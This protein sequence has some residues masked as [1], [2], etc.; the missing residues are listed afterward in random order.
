MIQI[1]DEERSTLD[2]L[3]TLLKDT[4][5]E[6][7]DAKNPTEEQNLGFALLAVL[8][9]GCDALATDDETKIKA[10][11]ATLPAG[12][13]ALSTLSAEGAMQISSATTKL[14]VYLAAFK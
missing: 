8:Y 9:L 5:K 7:K 10:F 14:A 11:F 12:C 3:S 13:E 4:L 6:G 2:M 1:T